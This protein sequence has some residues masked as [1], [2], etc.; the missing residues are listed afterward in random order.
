MGQVRLGQDWIGQDGIGCRFFC[1][2]KG[3]QDSFMGRNTEDEDEGY[4]MK[5]GMMVGM[6][7]QG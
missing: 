1:L 2:D 6:D 7:G 3:Y 5:D 4:R